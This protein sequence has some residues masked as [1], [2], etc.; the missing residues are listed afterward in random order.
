LPLPVRQFRPSLS[1]PADAGGRVCACS[2]GARECKTLQSV[3]SRREDAGR[4]R[5]HPDGIGAIKLEAGPRY[6]TYFH[7][8]CRQQPTA[9]QL[10]FS[11]QALPLGDESDLAYQS[12]ERRPSATTY[13]GGTFSRFSTNAL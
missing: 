1:E 6:H 12:L 5:R 9:L 10:E 7:I 2:S 11:R 4:N 8:G 3:L 13:R